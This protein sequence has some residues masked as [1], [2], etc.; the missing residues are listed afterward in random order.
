M[1]S[2]V[3]EANGESLGQ[4]QSFVHCVCFDPDKRGKMTELLSRNSRGLL[5][6]SRKGE[7]PSS[8]HAPILHSK[9]D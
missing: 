1:S 7:P 9:E 8:F 2:F 4:E 3:L 5:T 6:Y